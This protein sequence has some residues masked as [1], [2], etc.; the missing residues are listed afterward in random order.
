MITSGGALSIAFT[1]AVIS[2]VSLYTS[3][4]QP[5]RQYRVTSPRNHNANIF[6]MSNV[7]I[8]KERPKVGQ[9]G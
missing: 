5:Y 7:F 3:A 9:H 8:Q 2:S 6:G 4:T 1:T